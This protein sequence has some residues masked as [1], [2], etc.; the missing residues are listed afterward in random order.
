MANHTS[1]IGQRPFKS[2]IAECNTWLADSGLRVVDW[3]MGDPDIPPS[4][5]FYLETTDGGDDWDAI[6]CLRT[7]HSEMQA[8]HAKQNT[9]VIG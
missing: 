3:S 2:L 1:R 4:K 5:R 6:P 9:I 7:F 8:K